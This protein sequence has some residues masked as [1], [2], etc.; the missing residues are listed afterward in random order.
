MRFPTAASLSIS[1]APACAA[2]SPKLSL[3]GAAPGRLANFRILPRDTGS[4]CV[5]PAFPMK[6]SPRCAQAPG[7]PARGVAATS[8]AWD[9]GTAGANP[10]ALTNFKSLPWPSETRHSQAALR[11]RRFVVQIHVRAPVPHQQDLFAGSSRS[12][13]Q[14]VDDGWKL[15]HGPGWH[16]LTPSSGFVTIELNRILPHIAVGVLALHD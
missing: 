8:L 7:R 10:A 6:Q 4:R 11:R 16:H 15:S 3:P 9:Q 1:R 13:R 12:F 5:G 14:S 2:E